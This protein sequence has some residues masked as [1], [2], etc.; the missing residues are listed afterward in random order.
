ML[1]RHILA[2]RKVEIYHTELDEFKG[3]LE[4]RNFHKRLTNL[5]DSS[6]D[7]ALVK[8]FYANL[9][10][11]KGPSPKQ[12][13]IRGHLIRIDADNLNAFLETPV[14][15]AEGES[16]PAYSRYYRMPTGKDSRNYVQ[17][18]LTTRYLSNSFCNISMR[19]L[20]TWRGV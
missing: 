4:R 1:G 19:D 8:E 14:V 10:N 6:I 11:P 2:E 12:V 7:L 13:R 5:A 9:Y 15:L 16:L 3:E 17:A 20:A 18:V